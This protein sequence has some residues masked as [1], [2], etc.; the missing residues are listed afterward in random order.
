M[1]KVFDLS[2]MLN[3]KKSTIKVGDEE[4]EI[5]DSFATI[6]KLDEIGKAEIKEDLSSVEY[7]R[8]FL[9]VALGEEAT[10]KLVNMDMPVKFYK[11]VL[12]SI[13]EVLSGSAE[14]DKSE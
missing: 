1:A 6:L 2:E 13:Q 10:E 3:E 14:E 11:K 8:S 5:N 9:D 7:I 4:F 12:E